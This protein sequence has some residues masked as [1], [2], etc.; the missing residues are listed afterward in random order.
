M[1]HSYY[2][3]TELDREIILEGI[4]SGASLSD[5][6]DV[7]GKDPTSISREVKKYRTSQGRNSTR[8]TNICTLAKTCNT[9]KLCRPTCNKPRCAKCMSTHCF[10]ICPDFVEDVC[11]RTTR[12]P[13]VCNVCDKKRSCGF[14][15]FT[16]RPSLAQAKASQVRT[17]SRSGI[18]LDKTELLALDK[19]VSPLLKTNKQS[20][21][22][23]CKNNPDTVTISPQTLRRYINDGQCTAIRLDLLSAPSRKV[24]KRSTKKPSGKHLQDG[25]GYDDFE[26]LPAEWQDGAWELDTVHGSRKDK[27]CLLTLINRA[28]LLFLAFKI[29]ACTAEC[30][31]GIFDYLES[32]ITSA[33]LE[34]LD[35]FP[36]ILTD[37]GC[38]FSDWVG[39]ESSSINAGEKRCNIYFCDP[40]RSSQKP[41]I[42]G[43]HTLLRRVLPKGQSFQDIGHSTFGTIVSHINSY[44][45]MERGGR[46]AFEMA[47]GSVPASILEDLGLRVITPNE[48]M[49]SRNLLDL[50]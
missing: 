39:M 18:V 29:E 12:W 45:S 32:V 2:H 25:R 49:L 47:A 10:D 15:R 4:A 13:Y 6:S 42:E 50:I 21:E 37:N 11:K 46:S 30:V 9:R 22:V 14:E 24:R 34:F 7:V 35:I 41:Y 16:Y 17:E 5:I 28:N 19:L 33:G 48:V 1:R 27:C 8:S 38:E 43:R 31:V 44:P 20:P 36:H 26:K 23:I 3:L 40:Y